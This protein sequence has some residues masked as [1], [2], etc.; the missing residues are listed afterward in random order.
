MRWQSALAAMLAVVTFFGPITAAIFV[1]DPTWVAG[2]W[3]GADGDEAVSLVWDRSSSTVPVV[4]MPAL[5]LAVLA[6]VS[7]DSVQPVPLPRAVSPS[8]RAPPLS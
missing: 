6:S 1:P 7:P 5:A 3:D 4:A 2:L 8:S